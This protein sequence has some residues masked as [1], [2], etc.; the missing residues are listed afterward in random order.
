MQKMADFYHNKGTDMLNFGCTL[1]NPK[2]ICLHK[3]TT[4][5]FH[6]LTEGEKDSLENMRQDM[7]GGRFN[8]FTGKAVVDE[9]FFLDSTNWCKTLIGI[10]LVSL[11]LSICVKQGQL[12][13]T[14]IEN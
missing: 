9:S 11:I 14:Q 12:V 10:D 2:N 6:P 5:K 13:C 8:V 3:A 4:T 1:P 7:V